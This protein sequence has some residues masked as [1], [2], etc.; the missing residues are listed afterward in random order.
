MEVYS[1]VSHSGVSEEQW[2]ELIEQHKDALTDWLTD[3]HRFVEAGEALV[4]EHLGGHFLHVRP[5][6]IFNMAIAEDRHTAAM[7]V[8]QTSATISAWTLDHNVMLPN[9]VVFDVGPGGTLGESW[10]IRD[11]D[12]FEDVPALK[13]FKLAG[14][15]LLAVPKPHQLMERTLAFNWFGQPFPRRQG[16]VP[17]EREERDFEEQV[18]QDQIVQEQVV[19]Q[20]VVGEQVVE[21]GDARPDA[22]VR[23]F[24]MVAEELWVRE[25]RD[26]T[27]PA[28]TQFHPMIWAML[29]PFYWL[30]QFMANNV[31]IGVIDQQGYDQA[32]GLVYRGKPE[33]P[34]S[35]PEEDGTNESLYAD[36]VRPG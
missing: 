16:N 34:G 8:Q 24:H 28:V 29:R 27:D 2:Q 3:L 10:R 25:H 5:R 1:P 7:W 32:H 12:M 22:H 19:Q 21:D 11:M 20:Q 23:R 35:W 31:F 14:G 33:I 4:S 36:M 13:L 9:R 15:P 6:L 17:T 30:T 26:F 18:V